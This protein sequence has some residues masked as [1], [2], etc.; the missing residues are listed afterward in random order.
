[1]PPE[2]QLHGE[3]L[4]PCPRKCCALNSGIIGGYGR[5]FGSGFP[6]LLP[7]K[8]VG[9]I[10]GG[11]EFKFISLFSCSSEFCWLPH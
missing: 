10:N 4:C 1:M 7:G 6:A 9:L 11:V 2:A 5:K 8:W 3:E